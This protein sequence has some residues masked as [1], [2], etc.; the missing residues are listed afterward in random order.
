MPGCV[1]VR[2]LSPSSTRIGVRASE[3]RGSNSTVS[4]SLLLVQGILALQQGDLF[5]SRRQGKKAAGDIEQSVSGARDSLVT[6]A[7]CSEPI[8][9]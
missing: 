7:Q 2:I 4:D 9:G 5:V 8:A 1:L 3:R 6:S